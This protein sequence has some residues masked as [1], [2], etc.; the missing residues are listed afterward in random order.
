MR[1]RLFLVSHPYFNESQKI[2]NIF[3]F[4]KQQEIKYKSDV[5]VVLLESFYPGDTLTEKRLNNRFSTEQKW[6][7]TYEEIIFVFPM[8]LF[9]LTPKLKEFL[10]V[11]FYKFNFNNEKSMFKGKTFRVVSTMN[12]DKSNFSKE[13]V[14]GFDLDTLFSS[15]Q[16]IANVSGAKYLPCICGNNEEKIIE[17]LTTK[18]FAR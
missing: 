10:N 3:H 13:G 17:E 14:V 2:K 5:K 7:N 1:K 4:L 8:H 6:F 18:I 16:A 15:F 9:N 11:V 12:L